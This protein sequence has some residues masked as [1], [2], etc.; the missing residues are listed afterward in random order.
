MMG[1]EEKDI[2]TFIRRN[3]LSFDEPPTKDIG[4]EPEQDPSDTRSSQ[5]TMSKL[6]P[7]TKAQ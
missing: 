6:P 3:K 2:L 7:S 5:E 4:T 1:Q